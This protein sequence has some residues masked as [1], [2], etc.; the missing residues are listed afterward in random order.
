[1]DH[2]GNHRQFDLSTEFKVGNTVTREAM[3]PG[4]REPPRPR[5]GNYT[6]FCSQEDA[7]EG[8]F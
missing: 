5:E 8:L 1:M 6:F 4:W 2:V 3:W 7:T